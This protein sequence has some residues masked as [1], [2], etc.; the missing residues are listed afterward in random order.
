MSDA[1]DNPGVIAPPPLIYATA[2]VL[3]LVL[4]SLF[5]AYVLSVLLYGADRVIVGLVL[6]G[7][8]VVLAVAA[9]QAFRSAE[10]N[11]LPSMPAVRLVTSGAFSYLRNPMYVGMA[12]VVAGL[13]FALGSDWMLVALVPAALV[14]H[15][16]AVLREERYLE[17]KFGETYREYNATAGR[18]SVHSATR[19]AS[20]RLRTRRA[21]E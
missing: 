12:L 1:A 21:P 5:P 20:L 7:A 13:A 14:V 4:D 19:R 17:R 2:V 9:A 3:G 10:T 6:I 16:G 8:G 18:G 11:V 15:Y